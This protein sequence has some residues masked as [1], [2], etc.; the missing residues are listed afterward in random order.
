M[1]T[2]GDISQ[3][4]H[5]SRRKKKYYKGDSKMKKKGD[6][7]PSW[8]PQA[9]YWC[10]YMGGILSE[11]ESHGANSWIIQTPKKN[12]VIVL[13]GVQTIWK[14]LESL[15]SKRIKHHL[16]VS[17]QAKGR[18]WC[19]VQHLVPAPQLCPESHP[20]T[21][22][23]VFSHF[24]GKWLLVIFFQKN[25]IGYCPESL[26]WSYVTPLCHSCCIFKPGHGNTRV[27]LKP[28][29]ICFGSWQYNP[30]SVRFPAVS[31]G[32]SRAGLCVWLSSQRRLVFTLLWRGSSMLHLEGDFPPYSMSDHCWLI[33]QILLFLGHGNV[34]SG[35]KEEECIRQ[36]LQILVKVFG[37]REWWSKHQESCF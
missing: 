13:A 24:G 19:E 22:T 33:W 21:G 15:N 34:N 37:W 9:R 31:I 14:C 2:N 18:V 26:L 36:L 25:V 27:W 28:L 4:W 7:W 23:R 5:P 3:G 17:E 12:P 11:E 16:T 29:F 20:S 6:C 10:H 1:R 8:A 30:S 35:F 32:T